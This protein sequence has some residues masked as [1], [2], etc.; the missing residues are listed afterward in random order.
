[1][2]YW[3]T[4]GWSSTKRDPDGWTTDDEGT[5]DRWPKDHHSEQMVNPDPVWITDEL[6]K[7]EH[8]QLRVTLSLIYD[9]FSCIVSLLLTAT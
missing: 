7:L 1:M 2:S 5:A 9:T 4:D 6:A 3:L 8:Y